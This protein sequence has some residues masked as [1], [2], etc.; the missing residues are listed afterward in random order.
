MTN[1]GEVAGTASVTHIIIDPREMYRLAWA[2]QFRPENDAPEGER[3]AWQ[4]ILRANW[5]RR[6]GGDRAR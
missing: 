5:E 2:A 3:V 6:M 4:N 1:D